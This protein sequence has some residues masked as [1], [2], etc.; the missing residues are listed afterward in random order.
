MRRKL[1]AA[2]IIS[3]VLS[4]EAYAVDWSGYLKFDWDSVGDYA[5]EKWNNTKDYVSGLFSKKSEDVKPEEKAEEKTPAE[6]Q[7]LP[8]HVA[9]GWEKLT[10]TL[11]KALTLRDKQESLPS[12]SWIPFMEDKNS[13]A[14]KINA[15]LDTALSILV[16][17]E[18]GDVRKTA[19]AIRDSIAKQKTEL[20]DLR[21][22]RITA[23][24]ES[25]LPWK[26]TKAKADER[27]SRLQEEIADSEE[28][29]ATINTKL[30]EALRKI[31]LELDETQTDILLNSVTGDDLL[32]NTVVFANVKAV[33]AKLE[34]LSQNDNTLEITRRYTGMYLV[35]NDLLIHTQ[36]ELVRKID[37]GY[38]PQLQGIIT[39]ADTLRKEAL[40]KSNQGE[41]STEQRKGF[42]ANAQSN[43]MTIQVAKLYVEL[44]DSQRAGTMDSLKSLRLNRDLA[45][46]TYKTVRSSGELRGLIHSGLKLFDTVNTLRMPELKVFESGVMRTEF[47]EIN[48]R[49]KK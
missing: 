46:N 43:A 29:L 16:N 1:L 45:E 34:E 48:R 24:E 40:V 2:A 32:N 20:D 22:K 21:N 28:A 37:N 30:T 26:L 36:E 9:S 10:G 8:E 23:P 49:L 5:S 35:L 4:S 11:G 31:G 38:K 33:V 12:T 15:L 13:N 44:L 47:E 3:A 7:E 6:P 17:G 27:I 14:K 18:A 25:S 19:S 41:Y 42:A 39:E